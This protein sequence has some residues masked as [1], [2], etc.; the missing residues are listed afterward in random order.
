MSTLLDD[1]RNG[2]RDGSAV[3][4]AALAAM[5]RRSRERVW[6]SS[7]RVAL[8]RCTAADEGAAGGNTGVEAAARPT[9]EERER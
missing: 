6:E 7:A 4:A 2:S 3:I 8:R 9:N 1:A 5:R